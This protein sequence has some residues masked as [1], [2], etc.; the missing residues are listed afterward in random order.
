MSVVPQK[1]VDKIQFFEDHIAPW[2]TNATAI[3]TTTTAVTALDTK[4]QAA[5][6]SYTAQQ[7]AQ[8]VA[9]AATETLKQAVAEMATSGSA[10][11]DQ[12]RAA[13]KNT[14]DGVY[15]LAQIPAPATP[16]PVGAP[17]QP[18]NFAVELA[19]DGALT[20]NWKCANP[21]GC[22]GTIYQVWRRTT[23]DGE[24]AY[25][26]GTGERKFVDATIPAGSSQVTYQ[27]Q[28]VR[29]TAAGPWAQFNVN[30]GTGAGAGA[31]AMSA[32]VVE[33]AEIKRAA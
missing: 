14:G 16:S 26:G 32:A 29:S 33:T 18:N 30:F 9:K 11:I 15:P 27:M 10:I 21:V 23:A 12:I 8:A 2:T 31:G 20:I 19:A 5:R 25:L 7:V 4:T 3:G 6:D 24:F 1:T 17:G 28:A 22:V 13:A